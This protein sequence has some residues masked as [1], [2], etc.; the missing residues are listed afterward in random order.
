MTGSPNISEAIFEKIAKADAFVCD[1]SI[2][3][4]H[5]KPPTDD[6]PWRATPNPNVLMELGY[7]MKVLSWER[8]I[9]VMN[10]AYG[11]VELLPFDINRQRVT[12][13]FLPFEESKQEVRK[14]FVKTLSASIEAV[15][16][17]G[18]RAEVR[19]FVPTLAQIAIEKLNDG[20]ADAVNA[21][22]IA[23]KDWM[24]KLDLLNPVFDPNNSSISIY[25][26]QLSD[27]LERSLALTREFEEVITAIAGNSSVTAAE[28][29]YQGFVGLLDKYDPMKIGNYT[30][31]DGDFF[32]FIGHE[33]F[34]SSTAIYI[35][36]KQWGLL[37]ETLQEKIVYTRKGSPLSE[38]VEWNAF[39]E[40]IITLFYK[41][42]RHTT[43]HSEMLKK[44]HESFVSETAVSWQ[45]F[46]EADYFLFLRG[47]LNNP[48]WQ[49][50]TK[51]DFFWFMLTASHTGAPASWVVKWRSKRAVQK[52]LPALGI[53]SVDEL[54]ARVSERKSY[55]DPKRAFG[56]MSSG[57]QI[58]SELIAIEP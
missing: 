36:E 47:Q 11:A 48:A 37:D 43:L 10:T 58:E 57:L 13:Y 28:S 15:Y 42:N 56:I 14:D 6:V 34:V 9:L 2:I 33:W 45:Q 41:D 52:W 24:K 54:K 7:A 16:A 49:T 30:E 8:I 3:N 25:E 23:W 5:L 46:W 26:V 39:Y 31:C 38:L 35:R 55:L 18:A 27:A 4:Q 44:R 17:L 21:V 12:S 1:V 20:K 22:R 50:Y 51:G 53:E 40:P 29:I 32:R 19:E